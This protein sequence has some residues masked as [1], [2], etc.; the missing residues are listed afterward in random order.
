M[1][2]LPT[3]SVLT[4]QAPGVDVVAV[5][6]AVGASDELKSFGG[7]HEAF[8]ARVRDARSRHARFLT[9][10]PVHHHPSVLNR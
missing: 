8:V 7:K 10:H 2:L 6:G 9:R 1:V 4:S 5:P 3:H